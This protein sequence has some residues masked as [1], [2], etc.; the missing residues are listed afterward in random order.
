M[1]IE[2]VDKEDRGIHA[3]QSEMRRRHEQYDQD[4]EVEW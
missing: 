2:R 3:R 4:R 1:Y